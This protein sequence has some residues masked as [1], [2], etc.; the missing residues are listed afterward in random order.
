MR[1]AFSVYPSCARQMEAIMPRVNVV[2]SSLIKGRKIRQSVTNVFGRETE[3]KTFNLNLIKAL[4]ENEFERVRIKKE[5]RMCWIS[6][7]RLN[8]VVVWW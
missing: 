8:S 5:V 4:K 6:A 2:L 1:E 3:E 7:C